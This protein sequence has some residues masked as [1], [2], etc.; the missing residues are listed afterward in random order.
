MQFVPRIGDFFAQLPSTVFLVDS[1]Y[2]TNNPGDDFSGLIVVVSEDDNIGDAPGVILSTPALTIDEGGNGTYTVSLEGEPSGPV[3][4]TFTQSSNPDVTFSPERL[5]FD[6]GN[7][8]SPQT[9]TVFAAED[10]DTINDTATFR[11]VV[12][13]TLI[14]SDGSTFSG[15]LNVGGTIT[16]TVQDNDISDVLPNVILSTYVLTLGEGDIG[17]YTVRL[18]ATPAGTVTVTP[19]SSNPNVTFTPGSLTFTTTDWDDPQTVTVRAAEDGDATDDTI[20][21]THSVSRDGE[22]GSVM[23]QG[24]VVSVTVVDDTA[25]REQEKEVVT[26]TVAVVAAA[27]V[28]NVTANIG[29]RFSAAGIGSGTIPGTPSDT[30]TG[31]MLQIAGRSIPLGQ[32]LSPSPAMTAAGLDAHADVP[33]GFEPESRAWSPAD[34]DLLRSS[35]FQIALNA[36]DEG[37]AQATRAAPQWTVWGRGDFQSFASDPIDDSS[38][39]GDLQGVISVSTCGLADS[40]WRVWPHHGSLSRPI[41]AWREAVRT[42]TGGW[43]S[44]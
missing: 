10:D 32:M 15:K 14:E 36:A 6:A 24:A 33:S 27:T 37:S 23:I 25:V 34:S 31:T 39:D 26:E 1:S 30:G 38:Y 43:M 22:P 9:V 41:T 4:V 35:A 5:S 7:W 42:T 16:V 13:S 12:G 18:R 21:I 2:D 40:G 11:H 17:T 8:S 44:G 28:S 20:T 3:T 29:T 19:G